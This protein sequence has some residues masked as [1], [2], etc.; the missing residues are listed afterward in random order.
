MAIQKNIKI[1]VDTDEAVRDLNKLEGSLK[2]VNQEAGKTKTGIKDVGENGGAIAVLDSLTGGLATRFR[3]AYEASKLFNFS[4]KG[5]RTALIATGIGAFVVALGLVVEYWDE[6]EEA[7]T[8]AN[9]RLQAYLDLSNQ[10]TGALEA[11]L[12]L[13][14]KQIESATLQ[15]KAT[16]SLQAQ[17]AV[18][19]KQQ[20]DLN[21][22]QQSILKIQ[23]ARLKAVEQEIELTDFLGAAW[24]FIKGGTAGVARESQDIAL[25]RRQAIL[26][27]EA[28]LTSAET[29]AVDLEIALFKLDNPEGDGEG[30]LPP[31]AEQLGVV[32][33]LTG[34][35]NIILSS[36]ELLNEKLA[37]LNQ[38]GVD[39]FLIKEIQKRAQAKKTA[40]DEILIQQSKFNAIIAITQG[41]LGI[42]GMLAKEGSDLSRGIAA[43]QATINTFQGVTAAL[44]ATSVIPDPFGTILKFVNAAAIGVSG[45]INVKKIL[46]TKPVTTSAPGRGGGGGAPPAPSFNLIQGTGSNQI[47]QSINNQNKNPAKAFV[48]S[49]DVTSSQELDRNIESN[50]AL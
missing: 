45:A 47:S 33:G 38:E 15:G 3:D 12:G 46:S 27:L 6:I 14:D 42:I 10:Q 17:R 29:K 48:V 36:K 31:L 19:L 22:Q 44:S 18:L 21:K 43:S 8:G 24:A 4:L 30:D 50:S 9:K 40:D 7:I 16:E 39:D 35:D 23:I 32:N 26:E 49:K 5:L 13:L 1:N 37:E 2:E 25:A 34:E 41:T 11:Q 28:A 20:E